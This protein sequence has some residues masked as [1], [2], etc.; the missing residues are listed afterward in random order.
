MKK[1]ISLYF[2]AI[3]LAVLLLP[4]FNDKAHADNTHMSPSPET[5]AASF[6]KSTN[7]L[8]EAVLE[9]FKPVNGR[10]ESV[11]GST[12]TVIIENDGTVMKG[13]RLSVFREGAPFYHPVTNTVIGRTEDLEGRVEVLSEKGPD[14]YYQCRVVNGSIK[15]GDLVRLTRSKIKLAF[16]QHRKT[17]WALSEAFFSSLKNSGRFEILEAYSAEFSPDALSAISRELGAEA[18]LMFST[19]FTDSGKILSAKLFWAEDSMMFAD[20]DEPVDSSAGKI[21]SAGHEFMFSD[22]SGMDP[23]RSYKIDDGS[24]FTMGDVDGNGLS[25]LVVSD[26]HEIKIYSFKNELHRLWTIREMPG[27]QHISIDVLDLNNNGTAE[28]FVTSLS[29]NNRVSS[30]ILEFDSVKYTAVRKNMPYFLRVVNG[31][32]L[33]Q[34]AGSLKMFGAPVYEGDELYHAVRPLELPDGVNIYGFNYIGTKDHDT[35]VLSFDD[36]GY[37]NL[38]DDKGVR[39]WKSSNVYTVYS[40]YVMKKGGSASYADK[41][42]VVRDRLMSART[43]RGREIIAL[44]KIPTVSIAP[45]FGSKGSEVYSLWWNGSSM[46]EKKLINEIR[47]VSDYRVNGNEIFLLVREGLLSRLKDLGTGEFARGSILYYYRVGDR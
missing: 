24:L 12:V 40:P 22:L 37:L 16:F 11:D 23:E 17:D 43:A 9:L 45:G 6:P 4:A 41:E 42:W 28:I 1:K 3:L 38:F 19:P 31:K 2:I 46:E 47:P 18:F 26:G 15:A 32:L 30:F 7:Q 33:M 25:E 34:S 10:V 36:K 44:R 27:Y 13:V 20:I 14:G 35:Y 29:G 5:D 39:I 21:K 8:N